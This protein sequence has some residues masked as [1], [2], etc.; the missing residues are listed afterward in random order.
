MVKTEGGSIPS[1]LKNNMYLY[2]FTTTVSVKLCFFFLFSYSLILAPVVIL[3]KF[4]STSILMLLK[5]VQRLRNVKYLIMLFIFFLSG[6]PLTNMFL[7][8]WLCLVNLCYSSNVFIVVLFIFGNLISVVVYYWFFNRILVSI[9]PKKS[10]YVVF[11]IN[12][13]LTHMYVLFTVQFNIFG[14]FMVNYLMLVM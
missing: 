7:L 12:P 9:I 8:K 4:N 1:Y 2:M 10:N 3:S 13:Y 14:F 11:K 6:L 5:Q